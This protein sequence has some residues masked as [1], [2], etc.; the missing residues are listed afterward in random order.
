MIFDA[1]R[2]SHDAEVPDRYVLSAN[3]GAPSMVFLR[4]AGVYLAVQAP[5]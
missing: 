3:S 4:T 2:E 1:I 5:V